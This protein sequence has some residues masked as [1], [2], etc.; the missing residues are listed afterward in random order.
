MTQSAAAAIA[1][2]INIKVGSHD[3]RP[4]FPP[5]RMGKRGLSPQWKNMINM[6]LPPLPYV[7]NRL[8][9][10]SF[11]HS[12]FL[13]FVLLSSFLPILIIRRNDGFPRATDGRVA[14]TFASCRATERGNPPV[15]PLMRD[16]ARN[17]MVIPGGN[18]HQ[19][20]QRRPQLGVGIKSVNPSLPLSH[21][22]SSAPAVW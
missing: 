7:Q 2:E 14:F 10:Q 5:A 15:F 3:S 16:H 22:V 17:Y 1:I 21:L 13:P 6:E 8:P 18:V 20:R 11:T 19:S 12:P 4:P 9:R